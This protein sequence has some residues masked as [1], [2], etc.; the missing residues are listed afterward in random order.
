MTTPRDIVERFLGTVYAANSDMARQYLADDVS[1]V[2]PS[3]TFNSADQFLKTAAHVAAVRA[4]HIRK[5]S[6]DGADERLRLV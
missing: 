1:F 6:V 4:T 3:A 2:G 5:V